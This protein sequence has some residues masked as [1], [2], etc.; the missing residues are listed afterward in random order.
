MQTVLK[1]SVV[2]PNFGMA[3]KMLEENL[4]ER[5]KIFGKIVKEILNGNRIDFTKKQ[6]QIFYQNVC[7]LFLKEQLQIRND[8]N[9][10]ISS[11]IINDSSKN[12]IYEFTYEESD[13]ESIY[14]SCYE[15]EEECKE[16][17][18]EKQDFNHK[19]EE[20]DLI[21]F[22]ES[23][24]NYTF[25]PQEADLLLQVLKTCELDLRKEQHVSFHLIL[26]YII[27]TE[28]ITKE[29]P[30]HWTF[31]ILSCE[32]TYLLDSSPIKLYFLS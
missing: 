16:Q 10:T 28:I 11:K 22:E 20:N 7:F 19:G 26:Y 30:Y 24:I 8:H 23:C 27:K 4:S 32:T 18:S 2:K 5:S 9:K 31:K 6:Q 14:F 1:Y 12:E 29:K 17:I 21:N 3:E 25:E 13:E 15:E